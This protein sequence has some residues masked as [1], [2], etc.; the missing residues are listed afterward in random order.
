MIPGQENSKRV[1]PRDLG[2]DF[3][4]ALYEPEIPLNTGSIAR[5]CACTGVPLHIV[6][7]PGFRLDN[8]LARRAGLDYW[9]H[10]EVRTFVS[11]EKYLGE[12]DDRRLWLYTTKGARPYW[13]VV[14][15]PGDILMFGSESRG[16]PGKILESGRG[17]PL[18]IPMLEERRSLNLSNSVAIVLYEMLRQQIVQ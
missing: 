4:V 5:T 1:F 11:W 6:G 10:A 12:I 2:G 17:K 7:M 13:D 18:R 3:A 14:Y 15:K 9:E 8:R 16:L